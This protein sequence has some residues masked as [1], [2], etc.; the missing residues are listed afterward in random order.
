MPLSHKILCNV[1]SAVKCGEALFLM[2]AFG[3]PGPSHLTYTGPH[4]LASDSLRTPNTL[5]N[6]NSKCCEYY[7]TEQNRAEI[8]DNPW[9][10]TEIT[11]LT[12]IYK[13][14]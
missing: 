10:E 7:R 11:S 1:L 4:P 8:R 12:K 14:C 13:C 3:K 5:C 9:L 6:I 2:D